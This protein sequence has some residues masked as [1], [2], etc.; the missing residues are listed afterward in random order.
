[1]R[2]R[3]CGPQHLVP[4]GCYTHTVKFL[5]ISLPFT[6][7]SFFG[8]AAIL[9]ALLAVPAFAQTKAPAPAPQKFELFAGYAY[10]RVPVTVTETR[11]CSA[12]NPPNATCFPFTANAPAGNLRGFETSA[13]YKPIRWLGLMADYSGHYGSTAGI[14]LYPRS[15]LHLQT[16]MAGPQVSTSGRM[17]AFA[18]VLGGMA[19]ETNAFVAARYIPNLSASLGIVGVDGQDQLA[20]ASRNSLALAA[21]GGLDLKLSHHFSARLVQLDYILTTFN[22]HQQDQLRA[23]LGLVFHF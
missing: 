10:A 22:S 3:A 16:F 15:R 8:F 19:H 20:A 13:V 17:S 21:G 18:H 5:R 7:A 14:D 2:W 1:M 12:S 23:S 6:T 9:T 11:P 4:L